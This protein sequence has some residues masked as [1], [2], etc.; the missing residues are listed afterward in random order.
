MSAEEK[1]NLRISVRAPDR[2]TLARLVKEYGLDVGGGGP[3]RLPDGTL[4]M[5]AY[6]HQEK[7][8]RL[9]MGKEPFEVIADLTEVSKQRRQEVAKGDRFEGGQKAPRGLGKKE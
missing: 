9:T 3:R 8:V 2:D 1:K 4:V 7:L 6:V 5:D